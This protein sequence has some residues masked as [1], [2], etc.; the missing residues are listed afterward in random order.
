MM[1]G[2][3]GGLSCWCGGHGGRRLLAGDTPGGVS[4]V[5]SS[6]PLLCRPPA[7]RASQAICIDQSKTIL[8]S[9]NRDDPEYWSKRIKAGKS[10]A[11]NADGKKD[12]MASDGASTAA[13]QLSLKD[14]EGISDMP[15]VG[16]LKVRPCV[17]AQ[18]PAGTEHSSLIPGGGG[19]CLHASMSSLAPL[20]CMQVRVDFSGEHPRISAVSGDGIPLMME[21]CR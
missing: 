10:I 3:G 11:G 16:I 19:G 1:A 2:M 15:P 6:H 4:S 18:R 5:R 20:P 12:G 17:R 13:K 9:G 21:V 14:P 8:H 7:L